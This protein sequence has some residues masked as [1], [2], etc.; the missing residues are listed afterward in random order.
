LIAWGLPALVE[1]ASE[2]TETGAATYTTGAL[3]IVERATVVTA[4]F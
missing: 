1:E 2:R 4:T 3:A